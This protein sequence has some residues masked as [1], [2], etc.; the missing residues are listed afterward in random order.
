MALQARHRWIIQRLDEG[1]GIGDESMV[2]EMVREDAILNPLNDFFGPEG[3][4]RIFFFYQPR[5]ASDGYVLFC[6]I[7]LLG[8]PFTD[9]ADLRA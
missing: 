1:F 9:W 6:F 4:S 3:K 5:R 8:I 7:F 2:E